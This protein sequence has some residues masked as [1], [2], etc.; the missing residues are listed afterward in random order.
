VE[1]Q[2]VLGVLN[3]T[4]ARQHPWRNLVTRALAG[5]EEPRVE[6]TPLS[7]EPGDRVVLCSDGLT[8]PLT[9]ATI[10]GILARTPMGRPEEL[11]RALVDAA[12]SAGG[13]DNITVIVVEV[14]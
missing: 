8:S 7:L 5:A 1:E 9:N 4:E 10:G 6:L 13:P 3:E 11:C 2:V 12:N 14:T